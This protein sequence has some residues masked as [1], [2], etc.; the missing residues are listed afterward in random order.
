MRL[1]ARSGRVEIDRFGRAQGRGAYVCPDGGCGRRAAARGRLARRLRVAVEVS[2]DLPELVAL[3]W[4]R[5]AWKDS[6]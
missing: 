3:E 6:G 4:E 1:V 2:A 5:A